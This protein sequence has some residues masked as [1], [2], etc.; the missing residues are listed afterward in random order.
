MGDIEQTACIKDLLNNVKLLE[1]VSTLLDQSAVSKSSTWRGLHERLL[2]EGFISKEIQEFEQAQFG[3]GSPGEELLK[4]MK[5]EKKYVTIEEFIKTAK[6]HKRIDIASKLEEIRGNGEFSITLMSELNSKD[7]K[8]ISNLLDSNVRGIKGWEYFAEDFDY[9][10]DQRKH[11]KNALVSPNSWSPTKCL[12]KHLGEK[13]PFCSLMKL[14]EILKDINRNDVVKKIESFVTKRK[15]STNICLAE[16]N[17]SSDPSPAGDQLIR[18]IQDSMPP[19]EDSFSPKM[20]FEEKREFEVEELNKRKENEMVQ[21]EEEANMEKGVTFAFLRPQV[22]KVGN[23]PR[24][25]NLTDHLIPIAIFIILYILH[26][27]FKLFAL[28]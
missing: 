24:E 7:V 6:K 19:K 9:N 11:F 28:D 16:H 18:P 13:S 20:G 15:A 4:C 12:L 25:D 22:I 14:I 1:E 5:I 2:N 21:E 17:C 8:D 27:Q 26:H 3:G 23:R 10:D